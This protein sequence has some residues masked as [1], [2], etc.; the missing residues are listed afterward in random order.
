M[1]DKFFVALRRS[2]TKRPT[3]RH[4]CERRGS[5]RLL[6][7]DL[8]QIFWTGPGGDLHQEI[9]ILENLSRTGLGLF[10][11]VALTKGT[12]VRLVT[13]DK[14]LIGQVSQCTFKENGYIVGLQLDSRSQ[15][16]REP[17]HSFVPEH[18][19]DVSLLDLN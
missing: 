13:N 4:S 5:Q 7:S 11:G 2:G 9:V 8:V 15:V 1:A 16:T 17:N 10:M 6:C 14:E 18:L 12:Q 19:L 3:H